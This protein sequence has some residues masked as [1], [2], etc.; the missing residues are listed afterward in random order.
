[1]YL[2]S[3]DPAYEGLSLHGR[4]GR[5]S[6]FAWHAL[7]AIAL[8]I[9][10]ATAWLI[11]PHLFMLKAFTLD[12]S[13]IIA[14]ALLLIAQLGAL[15][16]HV[17]FTVRRLNDCNLK[18]GWAV[19]CLIPFANWLLALYLLFKP[20]I[21]KKNQFGEVRHTLIWEKYLSYLIILIMIIVIITLIML[22][23]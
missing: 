22:N 23:K 17:I 2:Y 15:Y 1:M 6:Y 20:G 14:L 10:S 8:L 11:A 4:F 7:L 16:F 12:S 5:V 18:I 21:A 13:S 9:L 19:L 3:Q